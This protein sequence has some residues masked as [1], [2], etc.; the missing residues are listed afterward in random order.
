[1]LLHGNGSMIQ[2][3]ESSG[4]LDMAAAKYRVIAFERPGH[5]HTTRP[6]NR[7]WSA[8]AQADL[9]CNRS[10][11]LWRCVAFGTLGRPRRSA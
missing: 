8:E 11:L 6:R 1:M 5:G 7:V 2:D 9:R 4:L 3:F 10:L